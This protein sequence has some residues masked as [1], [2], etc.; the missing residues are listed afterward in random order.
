MP[1]NYRIAAD[2][3]DIQTD[4]PKKEDKFFIDT[5]V[6]FWMTYT[7]AGNSA[8]HYQVTRY[9][10]Y[11]DSILDMGGNIYQNG[12]SFAEL[13]HLIERTELNIYNNSSHG[14]REIRGKEF[15]HGYPRERENVTDE[16]DGRA[17]R[18]HRG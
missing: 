16:I 18:F 4:T 3:I 2:I 17:A 1:V 7:R 12:L 10:S 14:G 8:L 15:R 13:A 11:V 5:N 6:W 9:P